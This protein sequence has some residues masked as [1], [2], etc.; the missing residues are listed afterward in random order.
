M[1]LRRRP[2]LLL[3][4]TAITA[5]SVGLPAAPAVAQT[6]DYAQALAINAG[7]VVVGEAKTGS[8]TEHAVHWDPAGRITDLGTLPG[9]S[10]SVAQG[11]NARG[12]VAGQSSTGSSGTDAVYWSRSGQITALPGLA[13]GPDAFSSATAI[14]DAGTMV[15]YSFDSQYNQHA[16]R[17]AGGRI[18]DLG[19]LPGDYDSEAF[20]VNDSGVAVGYSEGTSSEFAVRWDPDGRITELTVPAGATQTSA[21]GI[22]KAGYIVG[23][24]FDPTNSQTEAV[25]WYPDG[26]VHE[27]A[28]GQQDI[29]ATAINDCRVAVGTNE[30]SDGGLDATIWY[31]DGRSTVIA[32]PGGGPYLFF[33]TGINDRGFVI[34]NAVDPSRPAR[35]S[36][37]G[38]LVYLGTLLNPAN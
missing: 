24:A 9:G 28:G 1:K 3:G 11:I 17:W 10:F 21:Y 7:N 38:Q 6:Q 29:R 34:G 19:A 2:F 22:D 15:G 14:N 4:L 8:G 18:T 26:T 20:A 16:V 35:V 33:P 30:R 13:T 12:V 37:D 31:P 32:P 25:E 36:P 23:S 5:A 27:L